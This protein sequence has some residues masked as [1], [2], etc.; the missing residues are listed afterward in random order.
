VEK[1]WNIWD[2]NDVTGGREMEYV[3]AR[4]CEWKELEY[5]GARRCEWKGNGIFGS[6]MV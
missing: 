1:K 2:Q 4:W 5:A 3:G 6:K